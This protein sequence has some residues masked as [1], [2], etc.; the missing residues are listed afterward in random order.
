MQKLKRDLEDLSSR[1]AD[2][3]KELEYAESL[4]LKKRRQQVE[5]WLTNVERRLLG[6]VQLGKQVEEMTGEV[7]QLVDH[8]RFPVLEYK[9]NGS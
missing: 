3:N 5:N 9:P 4:S 8:G 1:K 7:T 2:V 6:R